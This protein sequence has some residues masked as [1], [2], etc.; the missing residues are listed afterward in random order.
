MWQT[1]NVHRKWNDMFIVN[2]ISKMHHFNHFS[3]ENLP[4]ENIVKC[5]DQTYLIFSLKH[6]EKKN[7]S[8]SLSLTKKRLMLLQTLC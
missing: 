1:L 7:K 8:N 5:T 4:H 3:L 6:K 2:I